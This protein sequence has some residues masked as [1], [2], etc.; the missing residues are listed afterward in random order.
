MRYPMLDSPA[1]R[2]WA[3]AIRSEVL[4]SR[5]V[6]PIPHTASD[7]WAARG[8][9][10]G[11]FVP[12]GQLKQ[13]FPKLAELSKEERDK[14]FA[15]KPEEADKLF[16]DVELNFDDKGNLDEKP[17]FVLTTYYT[18]SE[19]DGYPDGLYLITLANAFV[20]ER[21]KWCFENPD[22]GDKEP[23]LVPISQFA[24]WKE[25]RQGFYK[26]GLMSIVGGG[27][28]LRSAQIAGLL[29]HLE[30]TN[31]RKVFIPTNS[32]IDPKQMQLPRTTYI[33]INPGGEPKYE[34]VPP[35]PPESLEMF[36]I[37]SQE[38]DVDSG[39][40][41][42]AQAGTKAESGRHLYAIVA[43]VHVGLSTPRRFIERAYTRCCRIELQL[44]RAFLTT[45]Q[46]LR[47]KGEDGKY[48]QKAWTGADLI[49]TT[50]IRVKPGTLTMLSPAAK[51][52]F[53][54]HLY[55]DL[56]LLTPQ[57]AKEMLTN[58]VGGLIG[59]QDDPY[60]MRIRRQLSEWSDG[61]PVG[62]Q[63]LPPVPDLVTM[64]M[65]PAPDPAIMAIFDPNPSDMLP[66]VAAVR[67]NELARFMAGHRYQDQVPEWRQA[68]DQ[69]FQRMQMAL[70]PPPLP[71]E[72]VGEG[73]N[74]QQKPRKTPYEGEGVPPEMML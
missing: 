11:V 15:Y 28:E 7:I 10:V 71:E 40:L 37:M 18:I 61:P 32:I 52:Q 50:D 33:D 23:L 47:W 57:E 53:V 27:N 5:N 4:T 34:E 58:N 64:Q 59:L 30:K 62:W 16:P 20:L 60:R 48:Q 6:R 38:M 45:S 63:P 74:G 43:Q 68:V 26:E 70:M 49:G 8:A 35:Y 19:A 44:A 29:D 22:T 42:T 67:I 51:A 56:Q 66:E 73:S 31:R 12:W 9:Q 3:P 55:G 36:G 65:V 24:Q 39:M 17:I 46:Q 25:G 1:A 13:D 21:A 72:G 69:E 41:E 14:L 2:V 54:E